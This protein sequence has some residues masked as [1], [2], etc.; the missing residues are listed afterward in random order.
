MNQRTS[1]VHTSD[2]LVRALK[3]NPEGLFLLAAGA[4]LLMRKGGPLGRAIGGDRYAQ[5]E[6]TATK[7][8][9]GATD[10]VSRVAGQARETAGVMA[11]SASGYA[12]Y[13]R[14]SAS[15]TSDRLMGQAHSTYQV[16]KDHV[17]REKP[18][19]I[20]LAGAAA[21]AA[22]AAVL[23]SSDLEKQA[24]GPIGAKMTEAAS[25]ASES[26]K[27]AVGK[28]GEILKQAADERGLNPTGLKDVATEVADAFGNSFKNDHGPAGESPS[29]SA[30]QPVTG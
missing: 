27:E 13:A 4:V 16:T 15:A 8:I 18:L 11:S 9:D 24:I 10:Y 7:A 1:A 30:D 26:L 3:D 17:L 2:W 14:S 12:E 20:A 23:P 28:T 22:I 25:N 29:A 6:A 5:A 19:L 21:G